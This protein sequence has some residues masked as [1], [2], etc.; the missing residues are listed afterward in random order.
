MTSRSSSFRPAMPLLW[1]VGLAVS[2]AGC[3]RTLVFAEREGVN[4]A[5]RANPSATP[6][7]GVNFGLER[8]VATVVPPAGQTK[9]GKPA[10]EA[11]DMFAGFQVDSTGLNFDKNLDVDLSIDTQFAS[12]VAA[13]NVAGDPEVVA[14]IVTM[15]ELTFSTAPSARRLR[16]WLRP[17]GKQSQRRVDK[18]DA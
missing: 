2:V 7:L 15:R 1:A 12:G 13:K 5:V 10:G 16:V 18:L 14:Q 8:V 3:G 17:E 9:D 6:P 4:F 11:V